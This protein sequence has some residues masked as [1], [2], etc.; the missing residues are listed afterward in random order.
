MYDID[1]KR[2]YETEPANLTVLVSSSE[3]L[4]ETEYA[5]LECILALHGHRARRIAHRD[6]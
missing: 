1:E 6:R 5:L 4:E 2:S 3:S